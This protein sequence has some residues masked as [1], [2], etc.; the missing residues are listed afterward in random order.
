MTQSAHDRLVELQ[1]RRK[2]R[3]AV[4]ALWH[5]IETAPKDRF[6][7]VFCPRDNSRWLAA[8]QGG[9]WYGVDDYGLTRD[10]HTH[11]ETITHW[12]EIPPPPPELV[13]TR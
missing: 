1:N 3:E 4:A 7:I 2:A 9:R 8:W 5:P 6:V 13:P 11:H 12:T 10:S